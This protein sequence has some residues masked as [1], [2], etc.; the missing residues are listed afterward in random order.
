MRPEWTRGL[1]CGLRTCRKAEGVHAARVDAGSRMRPEW[2]RVLACGLR[3]CR[4][5]EGVH[6][7]R[8]DAGS[9]IF[10]ARTGILSCR[11]PTRTVEVSHPP[12]SCH[13]SYVPQRHCLLLQQPLL[14][15]RLYM[16]LWSTDIRVC[17]VVYAFTMRPNDSRWVCRRV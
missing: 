4:K 16:L 8:V 3:T 1:A 7:A 2:T 11:V 5:A 15:L 9:Y 12:C 10:E 14:S 6:A 17:L 13:C